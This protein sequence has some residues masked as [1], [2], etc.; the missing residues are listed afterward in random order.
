[1][2]VRHQIG[3]MSRI[4]SAFLIPDNH[5][6]RATV[7]SIAVAHEV[8][9][10]GGRSIA[11]LNAR[12]R[13]VLGFR[14]DLLT[15][16]AYGVDEFLFV[17]GDR[18]ETGRRSDDLTV[19]SMLE[20]ARR[21][22]ADRRL[23]R[24]PLRLGVTSR[25]RPLPSW[26]RD[27]D[28]LFVQASFSVAELLRWRETV[29]F[30]GPVFAGVLVAASAAMARKLTAEIPQLAVP[31]SLISQLDADGNAGVDF[32]CQMV[33]DIR[34]SGAFEGVHLIPVSRYREVA[35]RLEATDSPT[36]EDGHGPGRRR[37]DRGDFGLAV[38][39]GSGALDC[40]AQPKPSVTERGPP[41][42]GV[43]G[44]LNFC[45]TSSLRLRLMRGLAALGRLLGGATMSVRAE[46][47]REQTRVDAIARR[48]E[49]LREEALGGEV[50][51]SG[52]GLSEE[53]LVQRD[54]MAGHR[55]RRRAG[56]AGFDAAQA[57][58]GRLDLLSGESFYVATVGVDDERGEP[59]AIDWRAPAAGAYYRATSADP[60][61]VRRRRHFRYR[62]RRLVG[63]DDDLLEGEVGDL[64]LVGEAALLATLAEPRTG[65][66][67]AIVSTIQAAQD[68]VIRAPLGGVLFVEGGPGTGKTV[69]ALHRAAYLLYTHRDR[70]ARTGVLVVGPTRRFLRYIEDVIP[71]LGETAVRLM[72]PGELGPRV[73]LGTTSGARERARLKGD[74]RMA[75]VLERAVRGRQRPV[76]D[77]VEVPYGRFRLPLTRQATRRIVVRARAT[78]RRHNLARPTVEQDLVSHLFAL[79]RR[80]TRRDAELRGATPTPDDRETFEGVVRRRG[81]FRRV[82]E[83][84]WPRLTAQDLL[85]DLFG[86]PALL[87]AA[88][89]DILTDAERAVLYRDRVEIETLGWD[90]AD[91]VLLDEAAALLGRPPSVA[92][93][94]TAGPALVSWLD[95]AVTEAG[96]VPSCPSC[97]TSLTLYDRE[98][99]PWV[100]EKPK[101][102]TDPCQVDFEW[103]EVMAL[104]DQLVFQHT[105]ER[106][107][108]HDEAAVDEASDEPA[109]FG[110]VIVDEAQELS[111]MQWRAIARRCPTRS[112]TVVGD[113]G[114]AAA[115][116]LRWDVIAAILDA[117]ATTLRL[118]VNYRTPAEVMELAASTAQRLGHPVR[119][120]RS[121]RRGEAPTSH[122]S[123]IHPLDRVAAQLLDRIASREGTT[124][125]IAPSRHLPELQPFE[126]EA[127]SVLSPL[128]AKGL[129]Y[130]S[131]LVVDPDGIAAEAGPG[132]VYV[133]MTRTTA[134][135]TILNLV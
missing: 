112:L 82:F 114:Q 22:G 90:A 105:V 50:A 23:A 38:Y 58:F 73:P 131:V 17:F 42:S 71:S 81:E 75:A 119:P 9:A 130:D 43:G 93:P 27:A 32:A 25:L 4:A 56:L 124:A 40:R 49:A 15:A 55:L 127:I 109:I 18:P 63:I 12:D 34:R 46:L 86:L 51:G 26:K 72:T 39:V 110:H 44:P 11:C 6:G 100:C 107:R 61:G 19:R 101:E 37:V 53:G 126:T 66:M 92:R 64:E 3:V 35:A 48:I 133:A 122:R 83:R 99:R 106:L 7:S 31:E 117:P 28:F 103:D 16:A 67:G 5:I 108:A 45:L 74:A 88:S 76:R 77:T 33:E 118:E 21:F 14:R 8:T 69:V 54:A 129:E 123:G 134:R 84:M 115:A 78:G 87:A 59:L 47:A 104:A 65:R 2:R 85:V 102:S 29:D 68:A 113:P 41:E 10:M 94:A 125:I 95:Q 111:A 128:E 24:G 60:L 121:V 97:G 57:C 13:N 1:M 70:L 96:V 116:P 135:L 20:E 89:K 62:N 36:N 98:D 80:R 132:S 79:Y 30:D 52:V 91:V 120:P